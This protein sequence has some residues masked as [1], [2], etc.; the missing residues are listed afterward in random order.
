MPIDR[1]NLSGLFQDRDGISFDEF[2]RIVQD[3]C[4]HVHNNYFHET[5]RAFDKNSDGYITAKEIKKTMKEL[6]E[7]LTTKQA[8]EMI[9]IAD[10]SQ[11]GKLSEEEFRKLYDHLTQFKDSPSTP[12]FHSQ[13]TD[14]PDKNEYDRLRQQQL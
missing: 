9:K 13:T 2:C 12:T 7:P 3:N 5:F 4:S 6:G 8:K 14:D 10:I 1:M 11:N